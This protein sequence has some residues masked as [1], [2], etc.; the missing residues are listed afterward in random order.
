[1]IYSKCYNINM[2]VNFLEIVKI[3]I[4]LMSIVIGIGIAILPFFDKKIGM[5]VKCLK[6]QYDFYKKYKT[7]DKLLEDSISRIKF[8]QN[9]NSKNEIEREIRNLQSKSEWDFFS[10]IGF[11]YTIYLIIK[12]VVPKIYYNALN[13]PFFK[14]YFDNVNELNKMQIKIKSSSSVATMSLI[15]QSSFINGLNNAGMQVFHKHKYFIDNIFSL[16]TPITFIIIGFVVKKI[17]EKVRIKNIVSFY[18]KVLYI[19]KL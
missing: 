11:L 12:D 7:N 14:S 8:R 13:I 18:N 9:E 6:K 1:M 15:E 2:L 10:M 5:N 4:K 3:I 16:G 19:K 17:I